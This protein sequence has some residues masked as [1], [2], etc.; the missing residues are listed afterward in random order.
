MAAPTTPRLGA[1]LGHLDVNRG[2][3]EDLPDLLLDDF[4]R[5]QITAATAALSRDMDLEPVRIRP[6]FQPRPRRPGLLARPS[7]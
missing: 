4:G 5:I 2:E 7:S 3:V 6:G 1:M